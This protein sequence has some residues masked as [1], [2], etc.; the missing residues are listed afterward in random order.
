MVKQP[1]LLSAFKLLKQVEPTA[2]LI[3]HELPQGSYR[4]SLR[5]KGRMRFTNQAALHA[6]EKICVAAK[7]Q[8]CRV[9]FP[10][11]PGM[12]IFDTLF[13]DRL[14]KAGFACQRFFNWNVPS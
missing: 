3:I 14:T 2:E 9:K 12:C 11:T 6:C 10:I 8:V 1:D 5:I 4:F 13:L 7:V